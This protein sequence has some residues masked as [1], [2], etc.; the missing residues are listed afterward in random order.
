MLTKMDIKIERVGAAGIN[1]KT[2]PLPE[3]HELVLKAFG[4]EF[5]KQSGMPFDI[6]KEKMRICINQKLAESMNGTTE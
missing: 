3:V 1:I 2:K 5:E 4:K 6:I